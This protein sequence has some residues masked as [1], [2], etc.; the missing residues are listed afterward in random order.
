M[1]TPHNRHNGGPPLDGENPFGRDGWIAVARVMREH[2]I[3]GFG[4]PV[5]PADPDRGFVYSRAEAWLDLIMECRYAAGSIMNAGRRMEL[6]PGQLL[7]ATSWL[8]N[9]WNWTPKTVRGFLEKL[10]ADGMIERSTPGVQPTKSQTKTGSDNN[11]DVSIIGRQK[12][13]QAQVITVCNY[14]TYQVI[15]DDEGQAQG[16]A[17]G[18]QGASRGHAK[19]NTLTKEQGNKGT[20]HP[21]VRADEGGGGVMPTAQTSAHGPSTTQTREPQTSAIPSIP[22]APIAVAHGPPASPPDAPD[23]PRDGEQSMGH[24]VFVNCD[25]VRHRGFTLSIEAI[26]MQL[27]IANLGL[28]TNEARTLARQ[29]ALAHAM[30]WATEINGGRLSRDVVPSSPA[31]FIRGSIVAQRNK[32]RQSLAK[33]PAHLQRY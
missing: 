18:T 9:R 15:R 21:Q 6:Q 3:V 31:N 28:S 8:A 12:G 19:G 7:G 26:A 5:E 1:P 23:A 11:Y 14:S 29:A 25:T 30:Q 33:G 10:Q 16:Q 20:P 2:H 17:E 13:T 32:Q 4:R 22:A 24:G 27:V